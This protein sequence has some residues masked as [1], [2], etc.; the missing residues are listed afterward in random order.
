MHDSDSKSDSKKTDAGK[1][2][3]HQP[4]ATQPDHLLDELTSIRA[5]LDSEQ[6]AGAATDVPM[7]DDVVGFAASFKAVDAEP[8]PALLD[9]DGIF[10]EDAG[11]T[12]PTRLA[13]PKFTLDVAVSDADDAANTAHPTSLNP[14]IVNTGREAL[15]RELVA[16]F[17]PRIEAELRERLAGLGDD[18][19]RTLKKPD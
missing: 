8:A 11:D 3:F 14:G 2:A 6:R 10:D 19:L 13:F 15:I 7:L 1:I 12:L 9:L 4:G 5:L 16:E 17:L 18:A